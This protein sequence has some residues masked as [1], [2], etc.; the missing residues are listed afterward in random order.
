MPPTTDDDD[1]F[2]HT[3]DV[4]RDWWDWVELLSAVILLASQRLGLAIAAGGFAIAGSNM[5]EKAP[6]L[7]QVSL[8][9]AG[10]FAIWVAVASLR[11]VATRR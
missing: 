4:E 5:I 2:G 11:T 8:G 9:V 7:G 3:D 6:M 10:V 1:F